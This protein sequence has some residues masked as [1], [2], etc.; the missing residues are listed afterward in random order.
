MTLEE[1]L[2]EL[3]TLEPN[4]AG[5]DEEPPSELALETSRRA[6]KLL[7]E[8]GVPPEEISA[9]VEG[10]VA[11]NW[12][13]RQQL[14]LAISNRGH[15]SLVGDGLKPMKIEPGLDNLI[16]SVKKSIPPK[17]EIKMEMRVKLNP[18][19]CLPFQK[20]VSGRGEGKIFGVSN[21]II[22]YEGKAKKL[23]DSE[24]AVI[25]DAGDVSV[26]DEFFLEPA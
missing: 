3:T 7:R 13:E 6:L 11:F 15:I 25:W 23:G 14:W 21:T 26:M 2:E 8:A 24:V 16:E 5:E 18:K 9:D 12:Y 20:D 19:A 4:F 22:C 17:Y 10:G 1:E